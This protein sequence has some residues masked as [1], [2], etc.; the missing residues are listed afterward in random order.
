MKNPEP[1]NP[2]AG[3]QPVSSASSGAVPAAVQRCCDRMIADTCDDETLLRFERLAAEPGIVHAFASRPWNLAPHRGPQRELAVERRRRICAA[4]GVA[5]DRLTSPQQ[6]HGAEILRVEESDIGAG[7]LGRAGAVPFVDGLITDRPGLPLVLLSADC[8]LVLAYDPRRPALGIVHASWLGTAAGITA[9][10][11]DRLRAEFGCDAA[12]LRAAISPCA[13]PCC[14]EVGNEVLRIFRTRF[15]E[16]ERFFRASG[17]RFLLDLWEANQAQ[18]LS[19]G[20]RP[21]RIE[22]ADTCTICSGRFWSHRRDGADTG[23]S[24]LFAALV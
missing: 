15:A 3:G 24:A 20:V 12:D 7:R 18:L 23:R 10:L 22:R 4:L 8:P 16:A 9:R 6:V 5:F 14:Y 2:G 21:E 1:Q 19:A 17:D 13:G 11:V